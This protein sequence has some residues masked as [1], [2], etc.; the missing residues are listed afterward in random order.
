M[1]YVLKE[2]VG[3]PINIFLVPFKLTYFDRMLTVNKLKFFFF[4]FEK[5]CIKKQ[6][7]QLQRMTEE[8]IFDLFR[9]NF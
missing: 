4:F 2:R 7:L 6:T 1:K 9:F 8:R 3:S 5:P